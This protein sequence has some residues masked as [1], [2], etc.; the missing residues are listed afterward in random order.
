MRAVLD[1]N[2]IDSGPKFPDNERLD[3]DLVRRGVSRTN[4]TSF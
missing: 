2:N 3:L 1:T 4:R